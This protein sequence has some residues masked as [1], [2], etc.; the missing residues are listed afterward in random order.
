MPPRSGYPSTIVAAGAA[1]T[2]GAAL[3]RRGFR[4]VVAGAVVAGLALTGVVAGAGAA[5]AAAPSGA[6]AVQR[7]AEKRTPPAETSK[8]RAVK[9]S[10]A[11]PKTVRFRNAFSVTV[12]L[13]AKQAVRFGKARVSA[14][15]YAKTVTVERKRSSSKQ[16]Q[17]RRSVSFTVRVPKRAAS[18]TGKTSVRVTYLGSSRTEK[19]TAKQ[20]LE[21]VRNAQQR[22]AVRSIAELRRTAEQQ[23]AWASRWCL[24][25][26]GAVWTTDVVEGWNARIGGKLVLAGEGKPAGTLQRLIDRANASK[27][28]YLEDK[29]VW[30]RVDWTRAELVSQIEEI[31]AQI[32]EEYRDRSWVQPKHDGGSIT[33]VSP[34][35][36]LKALADRKTKRFDGT[37]FFASKIPVAGIADGGIASPSWYIGTGDGCEVLPLPV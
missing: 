9:I 15:G 22:A 20:G 36:A 30:N 26:L 4:I 13:S 1:S 24:S 8:K 23:D 33:V 35:P 27:N 17:K 2:I 34:W 10:I 37:A 11:A 29:I 3:R 25:T 21:V 6:P 19:A 28:P 16:A 14:G 5:V 31:R 18:E 32:P 7:Q 12:R